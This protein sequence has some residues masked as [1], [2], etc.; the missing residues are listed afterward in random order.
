MA[1][2]LEK[3]LLT[4][5]CSAPLVLTSCGGDDPERDGSSD[6]VSDVDDDEGPMPEYGVPDATEDIAPESP[7]P[8]D[9]GP[10]ADV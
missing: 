8:T 6:V 4:L 7:D 2:R 10:P 3:L 9:Y 5:L 1:T